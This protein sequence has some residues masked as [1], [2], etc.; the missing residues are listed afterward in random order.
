FASGDS[1]TSAKLVPGTPRAL[2]LDPSHPDPIASHILMLEQAFQRADEFDV[3]H[4]HVDYLGFPFARRV[5]T[6]VV[7]TLHGRLALPTL[8]PVFREY[9]EQKV[10]SISDDQRRPLPDAA[11][12][13]TIHHGLPI[14]L[15]DFHPEPDDYLAFLGRISPEKR[16]DRAI[17]IAV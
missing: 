6:P 4:A 16:V 12:Q 1:R 10:I 17:E 9:A 11:W 3:I 13:A 7:T 8:Q 5:K 14:D 2:R 15:F